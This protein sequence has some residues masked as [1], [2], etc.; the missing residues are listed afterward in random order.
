MSAY[1]AVKVGR[2]GPCV[3]RTW[4]EARAQVEG[5]AGAVHKKFKVRRKWRSRGA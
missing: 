1:Y 4:D 3:Y 5:F 2:S